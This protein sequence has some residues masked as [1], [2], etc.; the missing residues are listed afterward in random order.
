MI[1]RKLNDISILC[2]AVM[3]GSISSYNAYLGYDQSKRLCIQRIGEV[4]RQLQKETI[5][6]NTLDFVLT[7]GSFFYDIF[8]TVHHI[9][10][11]IIKMAFL[12]FFQFFLKTL[13]PK[14]VSL[15]GRQGEGLS[16]NK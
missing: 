8:K 2:I 6:F 16:P 7:D 3:L 9:K 1:S 14:S 10:V 4:W 15:S 13:L 11:Y 5:C 12:Y